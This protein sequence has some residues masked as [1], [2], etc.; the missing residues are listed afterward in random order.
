MPNPKPI[1]RADAT[2][3]RFDIGSTVSWYEGLH[4]RRGKVIR[5]FPAWGGRPGRVVIRDPSG[6]DHTID[7]TKVAAHKGLSQQ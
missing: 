1:L 5:N 3:V 6:T 2:R 7:V 4:E